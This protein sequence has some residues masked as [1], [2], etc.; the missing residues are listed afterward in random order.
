MID[1][2]DQEYRVKRRNLGLTK[3]YEVLLFWWDCHGD[4]R[5]QRFVSRDLEMVHGDAVQWRVICLASD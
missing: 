3:G 2:Q 5:F 1:F 4:R